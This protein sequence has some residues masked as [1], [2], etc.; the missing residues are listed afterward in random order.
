M[1]ACGRIIK[2]E[3]ILGLY[4]NVTCGW[5]LDRIASWVTSSTQSTLCTTFFYRCWLPVAWNFFF[6]FFFKFHISWVCGFIC[7]WEEGLEQPRTWQLAN[8]YC[9]P[10]AWLS[11]ILNPFYLAAQVR[12]FPRKARLLYLS[13]SGE[14]R[15]RQVVMVFCLPVPPLLSSLSHTDRGVHACYVLSK[16]EPHL[17]SRLRL[18]KT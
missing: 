13:D 6:L 8:V 10:L 16:H 18:R 1:T 7:L 15:W 4:I 14:G 2:K 5:R 12:Y 17:G 3:F 11:H 9:T